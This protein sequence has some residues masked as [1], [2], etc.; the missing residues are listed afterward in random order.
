MKDYLVRFKKVECRAEMGVRVGGLPGDIPGVLGTSVVHYKLIRNRVCGAVRE[1]V[2]VCWQGK[3]MR[4]STR[5]TT[6]CFTVC[7]LESW[8][9]VCLWVCGGGRKCFVCLRSRRQ[10]LPGHY[11]WRSWHEH[12]RPPDAGSSIQTP[13]VT[14]TRSLPG[15]FAPPRG[16]AVLR[17]WYGIYK[18]IFVNGGVWRS[19]MAL[20]VLPHPI[21]PSLGG[22]SA[23]GS[24]RA[25][26]PAMHGLVYCLN[27]SANMSDSR[28]Q[29]SQQ[30]TSG[31]LLRSP[32]QK[33]NPG[34]LFIENMQSYFV[35]GGGVGAAD[36]RLWNFQ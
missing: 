34:E 26:C 18:K 25:K 20:P 13:E 7:V 5:V 6:C 30:D 11:L 14:S 35:S 17:T 27:Q 36:V 8:V 32:R 21:W 33:R 29:I 28:L 24:S 16:S 23:L 10:D 4:E 31:R 1:T 12:L 2:C 22:G 19:V 9:C 15:L 3:N